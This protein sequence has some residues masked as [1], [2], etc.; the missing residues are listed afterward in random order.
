MAFPFE[1]LMDVQL[2]VALKNRRLVLGWNTRTIVLNRNDQVIALSIH[3]NLQRAAA[4]M[5]CILEQITDDQSEFDRV[6]KNSQPIDRRRYF[7]RD[8]GFRQR[9][10]LSLAR[11][12]F[13]QA[14]G[15]L[16]IAAF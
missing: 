8:S 1:T 14:T 16:G 11:G 3:S 13:A 5:Q 6:L 4:K 9:G 15:E 2:F 12:R 10:L 7:D